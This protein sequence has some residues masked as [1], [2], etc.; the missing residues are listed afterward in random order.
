MQCWRSW[1][2]SYF[3]QSIIKDKKNKSGR[4]KMIR[5]KLSGVWL[6]HR[7]ILNQIG[8]EILAHGHFLAQS[9]I[10]AVSDRKRYFWRTYLSISLSGLM[11][12]DDSS[13][14]VDLAKELDIITQ[15]S[16]PGEEQRGGKLVL[17]DILKT[18]TYSLFIDQDKNEDEDKN[19]SFR[20]FLYVLKQT[21]DERTRPL[22]V[23]YI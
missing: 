13:C 10:D 20:S 22:V 19:Q 9:P 5:L 7:R 11:S 4:K 17:H 14:H 21:C 6:I 1:K 3:L 16:P 12:W 8:R 18:W 23:H 2:K 15:C